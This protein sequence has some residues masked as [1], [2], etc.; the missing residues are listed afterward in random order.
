LLDSQRGVVSLSPLCIQVPL[1]VI[2][3]RFVSKYT[4]GIPQWSWGWLEVFGG[5]ESNHGWKSPFPKFV[6]WLRA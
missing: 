2:H 1:D 5:E 3:H 4:N 6:T